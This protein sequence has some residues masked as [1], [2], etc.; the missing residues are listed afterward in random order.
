VRIDAEA[1]SYHGSCLGDLIRFGWPHGV[2]QNITWNSVLSTSLGVGFFEEIP[3]RGYILVQ[4][5][6]L[7][8]FWWANGI[9]SLIF[10]SFHLPG[11]L[12]L[13]L[14]SPPL[15]IQI[16]FFS[17]VIG[18]MRRY[19]RSLWS[20]IVCHDANDFISAVLFHER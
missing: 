17:L 20:C 11:W 13:H 6:S 9:A 18:A 4:L 16:F 8:N 15:A 14:F 10:V 1:W 2:A 19:T 7:M 3:F 12:M 5:R